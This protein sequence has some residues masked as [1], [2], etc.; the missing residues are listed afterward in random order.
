MI[1]ERELV[2]HWTPKQE[3]QA[4]VLDIF[5]HTYQPRKPR[6]AWGMKVGKGVLAK[7][8]FSSRNVQFS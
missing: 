1:E 8:P 6:L 2:S 7:V 3:L 4:E 5:N